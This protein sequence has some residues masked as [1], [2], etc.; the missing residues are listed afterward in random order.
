MAAGIFDFFGEDGDAVKADEDESSESGTRGYQAKIEGF[1][2]VD[3]SK[4]DQAG[5]MLV[6]DDVADGLDD[7]G[8]GDQDHEGE[9]NFIGAG[10]EFD[11]LDRHEG[12]E[13]DGESGEDGEGNFWG[14]A[15]D[16]EHGVEGVLDRLEKIF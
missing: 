10:G 7:E 2:I 5:K 4:R 12:D 3:W 13:T 8:E 9:E 6:E 16:G 15:L 11:A 1:G 14:H